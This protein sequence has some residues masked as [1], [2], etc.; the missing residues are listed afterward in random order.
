MKSVCTIVLNWNNWQDTNECL[1]SLRAADY[2]NCTIL[3]VDNGSTNN[4]VRQI[5]DRFSDV[6]IL[7]VKDNVGYAKGNNAAIRMALA[8]GAEYL[9]LLNNDTRVHPQALRA[10]VKKAESDPGIG[11]VGSAI[12][13]MSEPERLQAWGGGYVSFWQGRSKPFLTRTAD[14]R[15]HFLTG[16]SLLLKRQV[17]ESVGLL[18]EGFFMYWEDADYC[19]RLRERGWKLAVADESKVWH[20]ENASIGK[21]SPALDIQ[22]TRSAARFFTTNAPVPIYSLWM[23]TLLRIAKRAT[24]GDWERVRAVYEGMSRFREA[25][26]PDISAHNLSEL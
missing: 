8:R 11:A 23:G 7:E 12:Y 4:S 9:W 10:L 14:N 15:L 18:D 2:E 3:V 26:K 13:H 21:K 19:F 16:A 5:R 6:E 25:G 20:K 22:Y 1:V 24:L 17:I